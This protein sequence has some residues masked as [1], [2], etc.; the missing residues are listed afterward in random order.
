MFFTVTLSI[1]WL[2]RDVHFYYYVTDVPICLKPFLKG[3]I[4]QSESEKGVNSI[5][6]AI[7]RFWPTSWKNITFYLVASFSARREDH[8]QRNVSNILQIYWIYK[9]AIDLTSR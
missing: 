4:L 7:L 3:N 8:L 9:E 6:L 5:L 1:S 2:L